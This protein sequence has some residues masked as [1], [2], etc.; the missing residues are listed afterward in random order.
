[1]TNGFTKV[2]VCN[3]M[4]LMAFPTLDEEKK[5]LSRGIKL[6]AG[7][8]EV[9]RGP[10]AGPVVAAAVVF[11]NFNNDIQDIGIKD[12]KKLSLKQRE[13]IFKILTDHPDINY[14]IGIIS[15]SAIDKI[16][17]LQASLAA[18]KKAVS[19]LKVQPEFLLIDGQFTLEDMVISQKA[20]VSGDEKVFSIAAAS[21]IAKVTRD[22]MMLEYGLKYPLYG[23]D[24]HK[25]YG[26][27]THL[28]ALKKYGPC[29][30]H[31]KS[32]GPVKKLIAVTNNY[33]SLP[34]K[35]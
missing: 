15:E 24:K 26:T 20:V 12:S 30:I 14:T 4:V 8:D 5:L 32:F 7:V 27:K 34:A 25:G 3:I 6:I 31:R 16:N 23:F 11:K 17:I 18:M 1:M 21:V 22:R 10:L 2:F 29:E 13:K 33:S 28:E 19:Q 35:I 9:G